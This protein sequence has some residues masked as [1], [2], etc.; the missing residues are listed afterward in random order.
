LIKIHTDY[1]EELDMQCPRAVRTLRLH[2]QT[3]IDVT[4]RVAKRVNEILKDEADPIRRSEIFD[5]AVA[6][7]DAVNG[8]MDDRLNPKTF[9]SDDPATF[10]TEEAETALNAW[11][12]EYEGLVDAEVEVLR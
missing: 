4:A 7:E 5:R 11:I 8:E 9:D 10:G 2:E 12:A 6:I 1:I 3:H